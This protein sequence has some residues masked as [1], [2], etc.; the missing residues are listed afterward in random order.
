MKC[1]I[2]GEELKPSK[3]DP[4]YVLCHSCRKKFKV[5]E[6]AEAADK[7]A[8]KPRRKMEAPSQEESSTVT[9]DELTEQTQVF[10]RRDVRAALRKAN[11]ERKAEKAAI[12]A[13][14]AGKA[15][16][17]KNTAST[18]AAEPESE[19][20]SEYHFRYANLPPKSIREKQEREMRRAYDELLS[21]G[22]EER[23]SKK[24]GLFGRRN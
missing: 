19:N 24:H 13:A 15:P 8:E 9:D 20:D 21:I 1:P 18:P 2:C 23:T 16:V 12:K 10:S 5:P 22:K 14:K 7:P 6:K 11:E 3:K 4:R 17:R